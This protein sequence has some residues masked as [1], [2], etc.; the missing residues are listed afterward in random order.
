M[1]YLLDTDVVIN[2]IRK[3]EIIKLP[4]IEQ[5]YISIITQAELLYGIEKSA[6]PEKTRTA[7]IDVI[8]KLSLKITTL[9]ELIIQQF[10]KQKASLE[11]T[12]QRLEDFDI[13]I[14]ATALV[15][16]LI[17]VTANK[18]HFSRIPHLKLA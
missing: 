12:G 13:L 3:I 10:A 8:R 5:L 7:M 4:E 9:N 6:N 18:R 15:H 14:A 2:H 11:I 16:D 17:L 1:M